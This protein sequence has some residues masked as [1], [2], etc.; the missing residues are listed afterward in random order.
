MRGSLDVLQLLSLYS[1]FHGLIN[2]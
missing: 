1:A 2:Q